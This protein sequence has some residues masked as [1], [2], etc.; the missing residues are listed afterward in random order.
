MQQACSKICSR[1]IQAALL[2]CGVLAVVLSLAGDARASA[3][4]AITESPRECGGPGGCEDIY[5]LENC[6]AGCTGGTCVDHGGS[7]ECCG[8]VY[9]TSVIYEDPWEPPCNQGI[10]G[11]V[12]IRPI[13]QPILDEGPKISFYSDGSSEKI[14]LAKDVTIQVPLFRYVYVRCHHSFDL[15]AEGN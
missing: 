9:Y 14:L 8:M 12:R 7:G 13:G 6:V 4:Y 10:C 11:D 5:Y 2:T 1:I 3:C 15:I